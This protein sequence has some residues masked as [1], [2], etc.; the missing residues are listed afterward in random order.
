MGLKEWGQGLE[1][2]TDYYYRYAKKTN[3]NGERWFATGAVIGEKKIKK[4]KGK[5]K[6]GTYP[7]EIDLVAFLIDDRC[8]IQE[9]HAIQCTET[10]GIEYA[11]EF[12][13]EKKFTINT[14]RKLLA[15]AE[16]KGILKKIIVHV[17]ITDSAEKKLKKSKG[18]ELLSFDHMVTKIAGK[19]N[20]YRKKN[21][22]GYAQEAAGW[23]VGAMWKRTKDRIALGKITVN[24]QPKTVGKNPQ[25]Q[26]DPKRS[27]GAKQAHRTMKSV[28]WLAK[29]YK[30][31]TAKRIMKKYPKLAKKVREKRR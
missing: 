31:K 3:H 25:R 10:V 4:K 30:T 20:E 18:V 9:I 8:K 17:G 15:T 11:N 23:L 27:R 14:V 1:L 16:R 24:K 7:V 2:L 22:K 26:K 28:S 13:K 21:R 29:N 19:F 12:L 5:K 6:W